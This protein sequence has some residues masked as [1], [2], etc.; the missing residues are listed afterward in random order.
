MIKIGHRTHFL[1][2]DHLYLKIMTTTLRKKSSKKL[3]DK[4]YNTC[5]A[6]FFN[7]NMK[8]FYFF[9]LFFCQALLFFNIYLKELCYL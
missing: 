5:F 2:N 8:L 9:K 4:I 3:I 1:E 6:Y 7:I